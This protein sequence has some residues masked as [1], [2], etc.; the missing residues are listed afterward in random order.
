[1]AFDP[2]QYLAGP[3]DFA[4]DAYLTRGIAPPTLAAPEGEFPRATPIIPTELG[5]TG[6]PYPQQIQPPLLPP[7]E[8]KIQPPEESRGVL[9][10]FNV[11]G[12]PRGGFRE[13]WKALDITSV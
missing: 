13:F 7:G 8:P 5:V 12:E 6:L 1:M 9:D 2:D 4:P 11:T 3:S 10:R